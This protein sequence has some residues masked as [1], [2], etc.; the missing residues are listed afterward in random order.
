MC[1]AGIGSFAGFFLIQLTISEGKEGLY[2]PGVILGGVGLAMLLKFGID[3]LA[4]QIN[5]QK[6]DS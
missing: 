5:N 3:S 6:Q 1:I 4:I 2:V